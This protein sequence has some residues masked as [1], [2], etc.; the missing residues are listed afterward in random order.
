MEEFIKQAV[1]F[2]SEGSK[3]AAH[4][5]LPGEVKEN[6]KLPGIVLCHGFAGIKE[7]LLPAFAEAFAARG[8][9][10]LCFDYRG[11]GESE[12][13]RGR[14]VPHEQ[15]VDIR[16]ALTFLQS[17][18][19]VNADKLGLWGTSYGGANA[20]TA[21]SLDKRVK[22]L[23]VQLTFGSGERVITG[24]MSAEDKEKFLA[25]LAKARMRAVTQNKELLLKP[26]QILTDEQSKNFYLEAVKEFPAL[27][28]R[29][30][31][32]TIKHTVDYNPE[33]AL[34]HFNIPILILAAEND[35]VNPAGESERLF[36]A[37]SQPKELYVVK[38]AGHYEVYKGGYFQEAFGKE[39]AWFDEYLA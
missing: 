35:L 32:L 14:L 5:Y 28:T 1:T 12:G 15:V 37:A 24:R 39:A 22:C 13:S 36:A 21:A 6:Q 9:A 4:L 18:D 17:L 20:M 16:H 7:L 33:K 30:S 10:A 38:G 2:Y 11:F 26:V 31:M 29:I 3:I 8:Y 23:V 19:V 25:T 34:A 27:E